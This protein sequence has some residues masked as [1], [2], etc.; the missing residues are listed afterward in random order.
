MGSRQLVGTLTQ[1]ALAHLHDAAGVS[2]AEARAGYLQE[3]SD[4]PR[5]APPL[6]R[7]RAHAEV[8]VAQRRALRELGVVT[9]VASPR[10]FAVRIDGEAGHA[11]E[12]SM[13]D[14]RD[15][16]AAAAEVVLAVEA[17]AR[18][19]P[20]ETVAT[21]GT[22]SVE[23]G[24]V[25]VIPG[26]CTPGR[27][28]PRHRV[29]IA[30]PRRIGHPRRGR[31]DRCAP[32]GDGGA[33]AGARRGAGDDGR[34]A[35]PGGAAGGARGRH[36]GHRDVVGSRARRPARQPRSRPRC[37]CS[38]PCTAGRATPRRRTPT[39]MRSSRPPRSW[40]PSWDTRSRALERHPGLTVPNPSG[41]M[42][43]TDGEPEGQA[44]LAGST[45]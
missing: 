45:S 34:P 27:R 8:H 10:R 42:A 31:R 1:D 20:A 40:S 21:V 9:A 17:A 29:G 5:I 15:A 43:T 2:A 4:L 19:E 35:R 16:L 3:L 26:A 39:W 6:D 14:R 44:W 37:C 22:L 11:G 41:T 30:G 28:R 7:L 18:A 36:P 33:G 38:C 12:V 24:A 32:R 23:P 13:A 25:S